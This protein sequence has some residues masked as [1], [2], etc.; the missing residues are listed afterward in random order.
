MSYP[1]EIT[2]QDLDAMAD[3]EID[4]EKEEY[5]DEEWRGVAG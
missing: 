5:G 3:E 2:E 1:D 4:L